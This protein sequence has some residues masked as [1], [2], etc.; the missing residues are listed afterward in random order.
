MNETT[1]M[2][3]AM[4][5]PVG[6]LL[7][8]VW[9]RFRAQWQ[10][11]VMIVLPVAIAQLITGYLAMTLAPD[12]PAP[13]AAQ[14]TGTLALVGVLGFI[15]AIVGLYAYV[16][17]LIAVSKNITTVQ[18]AYREALRFILSYI[19]I[20]ILTALAVVGGLILL[21]IPGI[22]FMVWFS[23]APYVL[24]NEEKRGTEALS[25]SRELVRGRFWQVAVRLLLLVAIMVPFSLLNV[26]PI[27]GPLVGLL[28][29]YPL[30]AIYMY[31]LY[32]NLRE[33]MSVPG[34]PSATPA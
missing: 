30:A 32:M 7:S 11:W 17:L 19:F 6:D 1:P 10:L 12:N 26:I 4:L 2:P 31:H 15:S 28:I 3:T 25:R 13:E 9:E 24:I 21:I 27:F 23:F 14:A 8:K 20:T 33:N 16:A 5:L 29:G 34:A 22:M 18:G